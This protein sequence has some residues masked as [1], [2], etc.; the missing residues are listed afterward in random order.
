MET[1]T[2]TAEETSAITGSL[3][4]LLADSYA[5]LAMTQVAHWNVEGPHFFQ[6]HTAF[7]GQYEELFAAVDDIAEHLR[8]L[9]AYAPG[10]LTMLQELTAIGQIERRLSSKDFVAELLDA[11]DTLMA[12]AKEGR[13]IACEA[14]DTQTEDLFIERLRVHEKTAW[15]LRSHLK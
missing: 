2:L 5:L 7:Q 14:G 12:R 15:M 3:E 6:L 1:K 9:G 4:H 11:H 13:R 10:G 8:A